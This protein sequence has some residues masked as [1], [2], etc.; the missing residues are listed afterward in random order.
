MIAGKIMYMVMPR[1]QNE[2]RSLNINID[3]SSLE[4]VKDLKYLET[5]LGNQNSIQEEIKSRLK[6]GNAYYHLV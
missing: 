4:I 5:S 1:G 3:N 6:S 2:G